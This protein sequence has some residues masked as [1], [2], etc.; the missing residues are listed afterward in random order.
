LENL[1]GNVDTQT[2]GKERNTIYIE[3]RCVSQ[4][5]EIKVGWGFQAIDNEANAD[6]EITIGWGVGSSV[7]HAS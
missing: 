1:D 2:V 7:A 3:F 4:C 6:A 5:A